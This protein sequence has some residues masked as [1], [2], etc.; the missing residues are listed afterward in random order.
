MI[1]TRLIPAPIRREFRRL[2]TGFCFL[3]FIGGGFILTVTALPLILLFSPKTEQREIRTLKLIRFCFKLFVR[4]MQL[5]SPVASV[6]IEGLDDHQSLKGSIVIANHPSLLDVVVILSCL[7]PSQ[8]FVK[9]ALLEHIYFGGLIR[10]AGYIANEQ[11]AQLIADCTRS[12]RSG[13]ALLIF[14][15]GT[16]SP[17]HGLHPFNRSAAQLALRTGAPIR[18]IVI[19]CEPATLLKDDPW[20]AIPER[21]MSFV[22]RFHPPLPIPS[23]VTAKEGRPLQVRALNRHFEDFFQCQL[24]QVDPQYKIA[25]LNPS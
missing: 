17:A 10:A 20:H 7:P 15:E 13:R 6:K 19:T 24:R 16:R 11:A 1:I 12:L 2:A 3:T 9:K 18:P 25:Q 8:C 5:L 22:L 4:Y 21:A 23:S 14:P